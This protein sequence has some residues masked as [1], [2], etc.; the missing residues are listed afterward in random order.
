MS[1]IKRVKIIDKTD[2]CYG[3]ICDV[4]DVEQSHQG[5]NERYHIRIKGYDNCI[6]AGYK[7]LENIKQRELYK[8]EVRRIVD[9]DKCEVVDIEKTREEIAIEQLER[10]SKNLGSIGETEDY[11]DMAIKA[12]EEVQKYRAIG[13]PEGLQTMKEHGAFTGEELAAIFAVQ[14]KLKE[15]EAIGT[16][17]ECREAMKKQ[18][19]NEK[20]E[21]HDENGTGGQT[22]GR[23][24][25]DEKLKDELYQ[26]RFLDILLAQKNREDM[27]Y[28]LSQKIDEQPTA[29]DTDKVVAQLEHQKNIWNHDE[30]ADTRLVD[31]KRKAYT[32]AI[33]IVKSGGY[34]LIINKE[35]YPTL[36]RELCERHERERHSIDSYVPLSDEACREYQKWCEN[37]S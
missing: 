15:Y 21:S 25:S 33:K 34:A 24:I 29:Y 20:L 18:N 13:T 11:T 32:M 28:A 3:M 6:K 5:G 16:L 36:F 2:K 31:E 27:F 10:I 19:V 14:M 7:N 9:A 26:Q 12:L 4:L 8:V 17:D 37:Q 30:V 35:E 22:M 23:L 1:K